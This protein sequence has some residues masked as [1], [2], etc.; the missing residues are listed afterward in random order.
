MAFLIVISMVLVTSLL[1]GSCASEELVS[2]LGSFVFRARSVF[3]IIHLSKL[4][5]A[6]DISGIDRNV[7]FCAFRPPV[8]KA[9]LDTAGENSYPL[10][11][12]QGIKRQ[13]ELPVVLQL[14][15][16]TN[17][18]LLAAR[19]TVPAWIHAVRSD[20]SSPPPPLTPPPTPLSSSK[21]QL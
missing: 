9:S 3:G 13:N 18:H 11:I 2:G 10:E 14:N 7:L 6:G 21:L 20:P 17:L 5:C 16:D 12:K 8:D 1:R 4:N 15:G 19:A